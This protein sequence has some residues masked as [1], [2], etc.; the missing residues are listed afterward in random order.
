MDNTDYMCAYN[1]RVGYRALDAHVIDI[2]D[3]QRV[4]L[5]KPFGCPRMAGGRPSDNPGFPQDQAAQGRLRQP[6]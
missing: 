4:S 2:A 5:P 1:A 6:V 3:I